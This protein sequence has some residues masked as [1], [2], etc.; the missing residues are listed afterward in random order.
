MLAGPAADLLRSALIPVIFSVKPASGIS[1]TSTAASPGL[2]TLANVN[3]DTEYPLPQGAPGV[4]APFTRVSDVAVALAA[5]VAM[6]PAGSV[7]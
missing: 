3:A 4:A 2:Y 6:L 5:T 1:V 7:V